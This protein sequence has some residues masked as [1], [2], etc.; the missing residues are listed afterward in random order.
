MINFLKEFKTNVIVTAAIL[1][2]IGL[3]L[4]LV[5][6]FAINAIGLILGGGLIVMGLIN[7]IVYF[8]QVKSF[9]W[10]QQDFIGGVLQILFGLFVIIYA[11]SIVS[12]IP[13]IF[14]IVVLIHGIS[15]I[16]R[17]LEIRKYQGSGWIVS[18]ILSVISILFGIF[19]IFSPFGVT[20]IILRLI[21][22]FLIYSGVS[23]FIALYRA[24]QDLQG[25]H[26]SLKGTKD[27]ED[28]T[29]REIK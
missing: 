9:I 20:L 21:G 12:L 22:I 26:D 3:V 28:A 24:R 4:L 5:P 27:Y 6:Q 25:L 17:A 8:T 15:A 13:L 1:I 10:Y 23:D 7:L 18:M 14:G 19:C 29:F 2:V 11:G 16:G